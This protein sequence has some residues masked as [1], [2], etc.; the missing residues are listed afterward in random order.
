MDGYLY[1]LRCNDGSFYVGST[2]DIEQRLREHR[3][4][5][6]ADYTRRH[7]PVELAY[8]ER[9]PSI[10]T[11]FRMECRLHRWSH[12][13]KQA[14]IDDDSLRL[15]YLATSRQARGSKDNGGGT[16]AGNSALGPIEE[17]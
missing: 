15:Q 3:S 10:E 5:T 7:L 17:I 13:K 12:E 6:G 4:G 16:E 11:A 8:V 1:I 9:F 2:I 14:L